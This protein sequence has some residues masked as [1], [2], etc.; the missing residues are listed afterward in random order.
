M[1][2]TS[3]PT[4]T[5]FS[6]NPPGILIHFSPEEYLDFISGILSKGQ[7]ARGR[8]LGV[9]DLGIT[10]VSNFFYLIDQ[11][12]NEQN[13]AKLIQFSAKILFEDESSVELPSLD[14]LSSYAD[15]KQVISS[16][17]VLTWIYMIT[18]QNRTVPENS[19]SKSK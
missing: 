13:T 18:F 6:T 11:R 12:V 1:R 15:I 10:E 2:N 7:I 4:R 5:E 9:F 19:K 14:E 17:I 8:F 3:T 16:G